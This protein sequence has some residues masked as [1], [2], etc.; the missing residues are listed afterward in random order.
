MSAI[1]DYPKSLFTSRS[2][3]VPIEKIVLTN[4]ILS[5]VL[6]LKGF[7]TCFILF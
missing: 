6:I 4:N 7:V 3:T 2:I 5:K 1:G